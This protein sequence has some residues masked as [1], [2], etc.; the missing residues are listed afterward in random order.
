MSEQGA[1]DRR[2]LGSALALALVLAAAA[3][4]LAQQADHL[5]PAAVLV[6]VGGTLVGGI[7]PA[8]WWLAAV[9]GFG[10]PVARL[11][12]PAPVEATVPAASMVSTWIAPAVALAAG[13]F[14]AAMLKHLRE[15]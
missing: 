9:V 14:G 10:V 3:G 5:L 8:R 11:W 7:L 6:I 13:G 1:G 2:R 12:A 4:S 15:E